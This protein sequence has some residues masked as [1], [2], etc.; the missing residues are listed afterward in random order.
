MSDPQQAVIPR[1][2]TAPPDGTDNADERPGQS[3]ARLA[4]ARFR[5]DRVGM[6]CLG[7]VLGVVVIGALAPVIAWVYGKSPAE[8]YGQDDAGLLTD[9]GYPAGANGGIGARFWFGLEPGLGRDVFTQLLYGIRTSLLIAVSCVLI[10]SL[11]GAVVGIAVGYLGGVV[12][13]GFE[14]VANVMLAFPSLLLL[15]ALTPVINSRLVAPDQNEPAWMQFTSVI[16][17]LSLF[18]WITQAMVLRSVVRSLRERE[19]VKA[20]RALGMSRR[21][22]V[23][24]EL[25]PNLWGPVIVH[26]TVAVPAYVAFEAALSFLGQGINEPVPDWGRMI[27]HAGQV[28]YSDPTY[29][30]FPGGAM[31]IFVLAFNL[32][33]DSVRD[34]LDPKSA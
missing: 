17:V 14:F 28:F 9:S 30:L 4:W 2:A 34:A 31:L 15:I 3:P 7:V 5:R 10:T 18:G 12:E 11:I 20:A 27:G 1:A 13:K 24:T 6:V 21:R 32:L 29:M 16:L 23:L 33:G 25:L 26:I 22:I 8:H 19:F